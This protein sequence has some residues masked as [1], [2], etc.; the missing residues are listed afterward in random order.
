MGD[1]FMVFIPPV[2]DSTNIVI[3][4]PANIS[5][6]PYGE[7]KIEI[8]N[9][10]S[11]TTSFMYLKVD[12][13]TAAP[14]GL[15]APNLKVLNI[16]ATEPVNVYVQ[17]SQGGAFTALRK[18]AYKLLPKG[19]VIATTDPGP[20]CSTYVVVVA[21]VDDVMING[22]IRGD[23]AHAVFEH[24]NKILF[25]GDTFYERIERKGETF[26]ITSKMDL[27][28][29]IIY[30]DKPVAVY[31]GVECGKSTSSVLLKT[32]QIPV[33]TQ[34][35]SSYIP[36]SINHESFTNATFKEIRRD[37]ARKDI[38]PAVE[39]TERSIQ[40]SWMVVQTVKIHTL[41]THGLQNSFLQT[42]FNMYAKFNYSLVAFKG[43]NTTI[44]IVQTK[45]DDCDSSFL[46]DQV[47]IYGSDIIVLLNT[48][49]TLSFQTEVEPG[50]HFLQSPTVFRL[51]AYGISNTSVYSYDAPCVSRNFSVNKVQKTTE[52]D[53]HASVTS[54]SDETSVTTESDQSA[55]TTTSA[56]S[57]VTTERDQSSVTTDRE[58]SS[59]TMNSAETS[60]TTESDVSSATNNSAETFVTTESDVS[61][62]TMNSAETSV[63]TES[64]VSSVTMNSA[65]TSV[66]TESDVSSVTMNSAETS[67]TTERDRSSVTTEGTTA[68]AEIH[69][70][71]TT[72][73]TITWSTDQ[74]PPESPS[75]PTS[76]TGTITP[77]MSPAGTNKSEMRRICPNKSC[78]CRSKASPPDTR[79]SQLAAL[80][81]HLAVDT[82]NVGAKFR[83]KNSIQDRRPL[84][85]ALG[86]V[87]IIITFSPMVIIFL[88]DIRK[89][90]TAVKRLY[91]I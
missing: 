76:A 8:T 50:I 4:G 54:K 90:V 15:T 48:S 91:A 70:I 74:T 82:R 20:A 79:D 42:L 36:V 64:D 56:V 88:L 41:D 63:T 25:N 33:I 77:N 55:E 32:I 75:G 14:E 29:T 13:P 3:I 21:Y 35:S 57:S 71:H 24:T 85:T 84:A 7:L 47:D 46:L 12:Q 16:N 43:F 60:V 5:L 78:V 31:A 49:S 65:E 26:L 62:V 69:T 58:V 10:S 66:T 1:E 44:V 51:Y 87:G 83:S 73:S 19:F 23:N 89:L 34:Q 37:G 18:P 27:S 39:Q 86:C 45:C 30:P 53:T 11:T 68:S 22:T 61:S 6:K 2:N 59:V 81:A 67:V 72:I 28:G 38:G 80:K 9:D 52:N 17:S 40:S